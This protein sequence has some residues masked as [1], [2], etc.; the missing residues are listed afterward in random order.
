MP[1]L[2]GWALSGAGLALI[3]LWYALGE[4]EL[5]VTGAVSLL[6]QLVAI[7]YVRRWRPDVAVSRR[8]AS[9]TVHDGDTTTVT[10]LLDNESK[11]SAS[12]VTVE[13]DV[14]RLGVAVFEVVGSKL[15]V[16]C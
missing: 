7:V 13:D 15:R 5:L 10:L 2:R 16:S 8:L 14:N 12:R 3:L 11:H 9:S 1:T 6:A 4:I